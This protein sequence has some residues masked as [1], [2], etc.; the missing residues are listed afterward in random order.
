MILDARCS[1]LM[2][3]ACCMSST[4]IYSTPQYFYS[5]GRPPS[6]PLS[7]LRPLA[8]RPFGL[9]GRRDSR[10]VGPP[11]PA[12]V[13]YVLLLLARERDQDQDQRGQPR[14]HPHPSLDAETHPS[15]RAQSKHTHHGDTTPAPPADRTVPETTPTCVHNVFSCATCC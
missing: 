10:Q 3:A 15:P 5:Y 7:P 4:T 9:S 2:L 14:E 8:S 1:M 11:P 13:T 12:G 6:H